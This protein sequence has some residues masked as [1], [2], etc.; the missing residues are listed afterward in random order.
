MTPLLHQ[1]EEDR[2]AKLREYDILDSPREPGFDRLVFVAAQLL[3]APIALLAFVD[4]HRVWFKASVGL[5]VTEV[6]REESFC[7]VTILSPDTLVVDDARADPRFWRNPFV[8]GAPF[9]RFYAGAALLAEDGLPLGSL[10]VIDRQVRHLT[11]AQGRGL[12]EL[13]READRLLES[14]HHVQPVRSQ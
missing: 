8:V 3:Q 1:R 12:H 9:I 4:G 14:T 10:C 2:L 11:S 7:S 13:A 5:A 6:S